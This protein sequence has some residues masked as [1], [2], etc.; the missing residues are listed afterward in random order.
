MNDV[1]ISFLQGVLV[2]LGASIPLGPVGVLCV[3]R[4]LSKGHYSGFISGMGA[5]MVDTFFAALAVIG[6][7]YIQ[8]LIRAHENYFT[9]F[10]G[11]LIVFIGLK[12]Y[13][14]NPVKQISQTNLKRHRIEDFMSVALLTISNPGAL[15]LILGLFALVGLNINATASSVTISTVLWGVFVGAGLWW[16]VLSTS[17]NLFRKKFRLRQLW[18]IN[19]VSGIIIMALGMI[20]TLK[21]VWMFISPYIKANAFKF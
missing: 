7:A 13:L 16:Y 5:A 3:Q 1:V 9:C 10:G 2:G 8:S 18:M 15:F 14:T 17:I 21:G 12:I 4:T 20:S 19:R 11:L 6:L